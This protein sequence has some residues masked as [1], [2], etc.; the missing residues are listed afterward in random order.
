MLRYIAT[1]EKITQQQLVKTDESVAVSTENNWEM[2]P[3]LLIWKE[4][5]SDES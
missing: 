5:D 2:S 4:S 3:A 1:Q